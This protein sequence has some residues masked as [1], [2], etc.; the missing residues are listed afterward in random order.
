MLNPPCAHITAQTMIFSTAL[1][2]NF[3]EGRCLT[4]IGREGSPQITA[5]LCSFHLAEQIWAARSEIEGQEGFAP[6]A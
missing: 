5:I 2:T 4:Y 1:Y 3:K 6:S